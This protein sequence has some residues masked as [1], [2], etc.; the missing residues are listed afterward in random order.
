MGPTQVQDIAG[1]QDEVD[2]DKGAAEGRRIDV[3]GGVP[4]RHAVVAPELQEEAGRE[5]GPQQAADSPGVRR[6]HDV[7][8]AL[9]L[10]QEEEQRR[11]HEAGSRTEQLRAQAD[12]GCPNAI[13]GEDEKV[14]SGEHGC[15]KAEHDPG[16][17]QPREG[18]QRL[19]AGAVGPRARTQERARAPL[20]GGEEAV[21]E[22]EEGK[23]REGQAL[24]RR[25]V[26]RRTI[27]VVHGFDLV[28]NVQP[29]TRAVG[30]GNIPKS[31]TEVLAQPETEL[32]LASLQFLPI[33]LH[34]VFR[35]PH[36]IGT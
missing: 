24:V 1:E 27:R 7:G 16:D 20:R 19:V 21:G 4:A 32:L 18:V 22:G 13:P 11:Q 17:E 28:G 35:M 34:F 8:H 6:D 3:V 14:R 5:E 23:G 36:A 12:D 10:R 29:G 25:E 30:D 33:Q 2:A 15:G 31:R 26:S 9:P